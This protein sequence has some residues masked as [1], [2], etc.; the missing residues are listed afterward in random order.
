MKTYFLVLLLENN[1][2]AE[3]LHIGVLKDK[4]GR[5][6]CFACR[7]LNFQNSLLLV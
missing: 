4:D 3:D 6:I 2:T 5:F 1:Q 7:K